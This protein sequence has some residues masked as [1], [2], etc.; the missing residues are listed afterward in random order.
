MRS[1]QVLTLISW[2]LWRGDTPVDDV[3]NWELYP[4][5]ISHLS[6]HTL[7]LVLYVIVIVRLGRKFVDDLPAECI[8]LIVILFH[9]CS[10]SIISNIFPERS[11]SETKHTHK[12]NNNE[13]F[14]KISFSTNMLK[15]IHRSLHTLEKIGWIEFQ[16]IPIV[17]LVWFQYNWT[18]KIFNYVFQ[19]WKCSSC[20]SM[21]TY[22][23]STW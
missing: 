10:L 20:S 7:A 15:S 18:F 13:N 17:S 2:N 21:R 9:T 16:V 5:P 23:Q 1:S 6:C 14:E 22:F 3:T 19:H 8:H 12:S 4:N 11:R